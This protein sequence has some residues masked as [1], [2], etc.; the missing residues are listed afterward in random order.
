MR[1]GYVPAVPR[2]SVAPWARALRRAA[3]ALPLLAACRAPLDGCTIAA[4]RVALP[5][6][7]R[8]TSGA[9]WSRTQPGR[10]WTVADESSPPSVFAFDAAGRAVARVRVAGATVRDWED[11]AAG[12]CGADA[13]GGDCL[14]IADIGDN[15][16]AHGD[17]IV[18]RIPEPRPGDTVSAPAVRLSARHPDGPRDAEAFVV[19]PGADGRPDG[20]VI[21]KGRRT[22]IDLYAMPLRT[23]TVPTLVRGRRL[24]PQPRSGLDRVTGAGASPDGQ[25]VAVRTYAELALYRRDALLAGGAP[26][27]RIALGA[28]R[29]AQGEAVAITDDGMVLLTSEGSPARASV[30][31]CALPAAR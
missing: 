3:V 20:L 22:P 30:L 10:W 14:Y 21:T 27:R 19:L 25:W 4:E 23:D 2:S 18:W 5:E 1:R 9:A 12:P 29:E 7:V 17:V 26:A 15:H 16:G 6:A 24:A 13:G 8:E 31:R 11:L 28:L